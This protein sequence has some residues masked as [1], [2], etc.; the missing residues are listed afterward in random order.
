MV[1]ARLSV[2]LAFAHRA[3]LLKGSEKSRPVSGALAVAWVVVGS[4]AAVVVGA[5][6]GGVV[7]LGRFVV[8]GAVVVGADDA[9]VVLTGAGADDDVGA[10][11]VR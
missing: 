8:V 5:V 2:E 7:T 6:V 9:G 10:L 3:A 4:G 11:T 1:L